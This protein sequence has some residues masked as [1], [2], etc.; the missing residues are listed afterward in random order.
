[1]GSYLWLTSKGEAIKYTGQ[2]NLEGPILAPNSNRSEDSLLE[3]KG[4]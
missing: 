4:I 3:S 2:L 1:M